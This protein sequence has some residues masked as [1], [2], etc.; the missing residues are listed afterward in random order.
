MCTSQFGCLQCPYIVLT[1]APLPFQAV[2]GVPVQLLLPRLAVHIPLDMADQ[3]PLL[4]L[5]REQL[6]RHSGLMTGVS[7]CSC[8]F[9]FCRVHRRY[10]APTVG[11]AS[12]CI[13][14][15]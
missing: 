12:W 11:P 2:M 1:V 13:R 14:R 5:P 15:A 9:Q 3:S 6:R 4:T 7:F 8:K 10:L